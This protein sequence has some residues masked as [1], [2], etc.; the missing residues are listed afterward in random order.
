MVEVRGLIVGVDGKVQEKTMLK[1]EG[2][3]V[4]KPSVPCTQE[5]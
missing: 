2:I 1:K 5:K 4:K 3:T